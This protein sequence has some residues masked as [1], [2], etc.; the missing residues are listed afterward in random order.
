MSLTVSAQLVA[1]EYGAFRYYFAALFCGFERM[2]MDSC[3]G[4]LPKWILR[5][6]LL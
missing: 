6:S 4:V 3:F 2:I 5:F 1:S